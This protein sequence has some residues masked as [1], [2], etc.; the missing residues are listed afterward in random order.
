MSQVASA[1][2]VIQVAAPCS[3]SWDAMAGDERSRFCPQ[4]RLNVY[5]L[6]AMSRTE[7]EALIREKEGRLCARF[8]RRADG[9][10][11]TADCPVGLQALRKKL[12]VVASIAA[13]F[14]LA[15]LGV[16]AALFAARGS[17]EEEAT[18]LRDAQPFKTVLDWLDPEAPR[19][20]P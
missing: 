17:R 12:A 6:S 16:V 4:C 10:V 13:A 8:Y 14:L 19:P 11:L 5:N 18:R 15:A 3:V 20:G 9:T 2:D 7:A 1:L